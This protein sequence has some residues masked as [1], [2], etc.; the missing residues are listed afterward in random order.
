MR[1]QW[2]PDRDWQLRRLSRRAIQLGL[3][4]DV[5]RQYVASIIGLED[6]TA[7]AHTCRVRVAGRG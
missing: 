1:Y 2:D 3:Q 6:V 5:V 4:G 7:L